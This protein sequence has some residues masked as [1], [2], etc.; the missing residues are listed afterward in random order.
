M[1]KQIQEFIRRKF[2]MYKK[3]RIIVEEVKA[4][5]GPEVRIGKRKSRQE[6]IR[7]AKDEIIK[8]IIRSHDLKEI[9][10]LT[11]QEYNILRFNSKPL[12]TKYLQDLTKRVWS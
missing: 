3:E 12:T 2:K 9:R 7:N 8:D 5:E 4:M 1:F 11:E 10:G 6:A